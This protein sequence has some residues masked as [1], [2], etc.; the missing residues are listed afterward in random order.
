MKLTALTGWYGGLAARDQRIL[1]IGAVAVVLI[2]LLGIFLPLQ[3]NLLQARAHLK[4][5]QE[6]LEWMKRMAPTLAAAGPGTPVAANNGESLVV[7]IDR[8]AR[9]SGLVKALTASQPA[10][11][12]AMR[13]Q[14][15]GADFN[16]LLG[17][18]HRLTTQQGLHVEDASVTSSGNPGIVNASL[19]LRPGK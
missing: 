9:E 6:D 11:N 14:F 13:V 15:T 4:Q 17:W 2:L 10:G 12:G 16:L 5:Q 1:R 19:Q 7:V 18:L 3:R 8:T